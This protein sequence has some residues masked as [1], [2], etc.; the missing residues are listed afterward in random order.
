MYRNLISNYVYKIYSSSILIDFDY[1]FISHIMNHKFYR[2][3]N[4][5]PIFNFSF[6]VKKYCVTY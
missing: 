5:P 1:I 2:T 6:I 4:N 3:F